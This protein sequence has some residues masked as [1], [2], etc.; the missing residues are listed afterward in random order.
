MH[1]V[2]ERIAVIDLG[3]NSTRLLVAEV[4]DGSVRE[5]ARRTEITRLGEGVDANGRLAEAAIERVLDVLAR[6]REEIDRLEARELVAVATSAVR[7][8][9]NGE[10]FRAML[11]ERF[12]IDARTISGD[13]EAR[14]TFMGATAALSSEAEPTL[15]LDIGGGSTEFVAGRPGSEP[16]FHVSTKLGS[17][18]QTERHLHDD[19]PTAEQV[20]SM[21]AEV[22]ETI[23]A[24]VPDTVRSNVAAGIAVAGTATSV[25]A[26]DLELDPY[27]PGRVEGHQLALGETERILA[28]LAELPVERRRRVTGLHPERA[29][30]IVAGAAI[31]VEAMKAFGLDPIKVSEAD[32]LHGAALAAGGVNTA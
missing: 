23:A 1:A 24:E 8:A 5:L 2:S 10:E 21:A 26:I 31:L 22:R 17:V 19:P 29:P 3:T 7:D 15:V 20:E 13:E 16:G 14:L 11:R 27:D 32:I 28:M 25:A 12:G 9:D 30:T 4:E 6:Y 18:R